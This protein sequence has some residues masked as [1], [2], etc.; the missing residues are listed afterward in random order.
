MSKEWKPGDLAM[1]SGLDGD[2]VMAF[3]QDR[4][5]ATQSHLYLNDWQVKARPLVVIDP[6]DREA[7]ERLTGL[8]L[9]VEGSATDVMQAALREFADPTPP[10][11]DEPTGLGA[12]VEDED[13]SILTRISLEGGRDWVTIHGTAFEWSEIDVARIVGSGVQP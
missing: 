10:R 1:L 12:V 6:E 4:Q 8:Y 13:G 2:E 9:D 3:R 7:V 11:P 5:W